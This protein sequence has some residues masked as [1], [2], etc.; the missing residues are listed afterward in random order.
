MRYENNA[1][2]VNTNEHRFEM[3]VEGNIAFI[4][5]KQRDKKLYLTH[6]EMPPEL[7]GKGVGSTLVEKTLQYIKEHHLQLVPYCP[8]IQS[9]LQR[10]PEWKRLEKAEK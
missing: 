10:H 4:E 8:F 3:D 9:F 2:H 7:E 1:F 6:T 5:Y